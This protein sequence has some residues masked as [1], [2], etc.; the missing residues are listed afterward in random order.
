MTLNSFDSN[1]QDIV[2]QEEVTA[3][4]LMTAYPFTLTH[5]NNVITFISRL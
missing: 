3:K 5:E 4:S 1:V 2:G